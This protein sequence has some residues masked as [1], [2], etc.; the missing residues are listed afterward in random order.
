[1]YI[2]NPTLQKRNGTHGQFSEWRLI[3]VNSEFHTVHS[4]KLAAKPKAER[5]QPV[6]LF[7][8]S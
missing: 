1:M 7:T 8:H 5:I 3:V 6:L 4:P 2:F